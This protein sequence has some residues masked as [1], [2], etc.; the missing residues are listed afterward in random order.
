MTDKSK[1]V[2]KELAEVLERNDAHFNIQ[3]S[4]EYTHDVRSPME[5]LLDLVVYNICTD[6]L[7]TSPV[8]V[9]DSSVLLTH[10]KLINAI[11]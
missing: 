7:D 10:T 6:E 4:R 8:I 3:L 5:L 1:Q 9:A 2:L 11:K